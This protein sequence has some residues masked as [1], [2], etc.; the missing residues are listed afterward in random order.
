MQ[1]FVSAE[2]ITR[3]GEAKCA[4]RQFDNMRLLLGVRSKNEKANAPKQLTFFRKKLVLGSLQCA[5]NFWG[6]AP[7]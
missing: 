7:L 3:D 2:Q 4:I 6:I 5:T 1:A